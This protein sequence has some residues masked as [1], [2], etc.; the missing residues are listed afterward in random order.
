MPVD[1]RHIKNSSETKT[2][3][4]YNELI[5]KII[6][7]FEDKHLELEVPPGA[8][9]INDPVI[10]GYNRGI[11]GLWIDHWPSQVKAEPDSDK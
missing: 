11:C 6:Q 3:F 7:R 10:N 5:L 4:Y 8:W 2:E 1:F 9:K